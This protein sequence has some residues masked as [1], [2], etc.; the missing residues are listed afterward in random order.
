[1]KSNFKRIISGIIAGIMLFSQASIVNATL[2]PIEEVKVSV[3]YS[4]ALPGELRCMK[5]SDILNDM[6]TEDKKHVAVKKDAEVVWSRFTGDSGDFEDDAWK[7]TEMSNTIDLMPVFYNS[8]ATMELIVGSG[9]QL[10]PENVRYILD[11]KGPELKEV[12]N[13]DFYFQGEVSMGDGT[14][15]TIRNKVDFTPSYYKR[16]FTN[17]NGITDIQSNL[18]FSIAPEYNAD[19]Y[20][21]AYMT[22]KSENYPDAEMSVYDGRFDSA[23]AAIEAARKDPEIDVTEKLAAPDMSL[24]DAG[25]GSRYADKK[26]RRMLTT[27]YKRNGE[28]VGFDYFYLTA[29]PRSNSIMYNDM[30]SIDKE[31]KTIPVEGSHTTYFDMYGA[32]V[33][34]YDMAP[35][36]PAN[37]EYY[38][39]LSFYDGDK[40][41]LNND[42]VVKAVEGQYASIQAAKDQPDIKDTL[43]ADPH[44]EDFEANKV[45]KANYS[46]EGKS[47]TVF[48]GNAGAEVWKI[49]VL[50]EDIVEEENVI[51]YEEEPDPFSD[52]KYFS[53]RE[54]VDGGN[55]VDTYVVPYDQDSYYS[56]GYQTLLV[57][58]TEQSLKNLS[59]EARLGYH[60]K[61]Y[62]NG[63]VEDTQDQEDNEYVSAVL[64][65]S[66]FTKES[67]DKATT[68][69]GSV[70]YTVSAENH[71]DHKNYWI[72]A[73]KKEKGSKLFVNGPDTREIFI[74]N[75]YGNVHDIFVANVGTEELK[76]IKVTLDSNNIVLD[77]YW[78]IGGSGNDTLAPFNTT[79]NATDNRRGELPN[80]AKIRLLAKGEGDLS[81]VLTITADGQT[82]RVINIT[83]KAGNPKIDTTSLHDGVIYVPYS[84]IITTNNMHDW[85]R[86]TFS[87]EEGNLP[88]GVELLPSGEIYGVPRETGT[89][90]I[91]VKAEFSS[92]E[93]EP[94]YADLTLNILE[95]TDENVNA[96]IDEG[97]E[98]LVRIP[99]IVVEEGEV[100]VPQLLEFKYD[101]AEHMDEFQGVWLDGTKLVK[102]VDYTVEPGSTAITTTSQTL[103]NMSDGGHTIAAEYRNTDNKLQKTAQNI[104]KKTVNTKA[105]VSAP[106]SVPV[107]TAAAS[108]GS[109]NK[110]TA[111]ASSG[112]SNKNTASAAKKE[113]TYKP[114]KI[115]YYT[116]SYAANGGSKT[117]P[118][119]VQSGRKLYYLPTPEKSGYKLEGWY[120]DEELTEKFDSEKPVIS[121][122]TLYAKWE[123]VVCR[124]WFDENGGSKV[125]SREAMGD[126]EME[127]LPKPKKTGYTFEGWYTSPDFEQQFYEGS[128]V[129]KN[130]VLYAKW[131]EIPVPPLPPQNAADFVDINKDL[132]YYEDVD[133]AYGSKLI[134]PYNNAVFGPDEYITLGNFV[135]AMAILSGE[136]LS[137]FENVDYDGIENYRWYSSYAKWAYERV[138]K[139]Q[140]VF[141]PDSVVTREEAACMIEKYLK[142]MNAGYGAAEGY[143]VF[144][145]SED[146]SP[147]AMEAVQVL[148]KNGILSGKGG[149]TIAPKE[150][151]SKAEF[152]AMIHRVNYFIYNK[153]AD[154]TVKS[155][156]ENDK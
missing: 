22:L 91:R 13:L 92:M 23:E 28:I 81:G 39:S 51:E 29:D 106:A 126:T 131:K 57:N 82:P 139:P 88:K 150:V 145:D 105:S 3:D 35:E 33:I 127:M 78:T 99:D 65:P 125:E 102:G 151:I 6:V 84:S 114:V 98:I 68:P 61:V 137:R 1:M 147:D 63:K 141:D 96:Q 9:N 146:I 27:V 5:V 80:V 42:L 69:D 94:S 101:Y 14:T 71:I 132:W 26:E 155:A 12:F 67:S 97:F 110:N 64:S 75:H 7:V 133:W 129:Y 122:M 54:L 112:S 118:T 55:N 128:K 153:R 32:K 85:N 123:R 47:F 83:G 43:F 66:D 2:L 46:G 93:F 70:R 58:S 134:D 38:F 149:N 144:D 53:V 41:E 117:E 115:V 16:K 59:P 108:G 8:S 79:Y 90:K 30:Y 76:G 73:V 116:V 119:Q 120:T 17:E 19:G 86:V 72:T 10:D 11:I 40:N 142:Y 89:F 152:A 103:A 62:K 140:E 24:I 44:S 74:N 77:D 138:M 104:Q 130:M 20:Y 135:K 143:V 87:L 45:Y 34:K 109:S 148:Y 25:L 21:F 124:V 121:D 154:L 31:N 18:R 4:D 48:S 107:K 56:L 156:N 136:D 60:A 49:K 95:N 36:T 50:A 52:D 111:A 100:L 37:N 15:R 113:S